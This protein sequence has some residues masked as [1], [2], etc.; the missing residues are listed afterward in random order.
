MREGLADNDKKL[1]SLV[2][3]WNRY[4]P[5]SRI[6]DYSVINS[7]LD[8][9]VEYV[10]SVAVPSYAQLIDENLIFRSFFIASDLFQAYAMNRERHFPIVIPERATTREKLRYTLP[11]GYKPYSVPKSEEFG[12]EK[13]SCSVNYTVS[14]TGIEVVSIIKI[15]CFVIDINE[16]E[17]FRNF[18]LFLKRKESERIILVRE[19]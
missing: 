9:P 8:E 10:Y 11:E 6:S 7:A 13:F 12:N 5:G 19:P 18:T 15:N 14:E 4:Y 16:Y 17:N 1:N 3:Y 2:E